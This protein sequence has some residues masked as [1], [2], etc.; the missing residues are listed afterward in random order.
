MKLMQN[1]D[2]EVCAKKTGVIIGHIMN[3]GTSPGIME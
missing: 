1:T 3:A 2:K